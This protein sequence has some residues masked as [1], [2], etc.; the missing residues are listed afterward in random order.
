MSSPKNPQT[1]LDRDNWMRAV[2]ASGEPYAARCL[3]I[4]IALHLSVQKGRCD[5]GHKALRQDTGMSTRSVERWAARLERDGWLGIKH[6]GRGHTNSY[7]L[8]TPAAAM[9]R[10]HVAD[11]KPHMTRQR[12]ADQTSFLDF[13]PPLPAD[14][15]RHIASDDPP[16][17]VGQKSVLNN[18]KRKAEK[19]DSPADFA[20]RPE[21]DKPTRRRKNPDPTP[22]GADLADAFD[23]FWAAY[24]RKVAKEAAR[25]AF[26][27]A[28]EGVGNPDTLVAGAQRYAVERSGEPPKYT[29]HP[30]TWLNAG[31]W[32]DE[33]PGA[34]IIDQEGNVV[35]V[36][37]P[38]PQRRRTGFTAVADQLI[39]ELEAEGKLNTWQW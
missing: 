20:P 2:L 21:E 32:E 24:P 26:A 19:K 23:R 31:C 18:E 36:E 34:P 37:Q 3:A 8:T 35:A 13:D 29:K 10:Q 30:A 33:L 6:G 28:V 12:V 16:H 25:K 9:T 1:F 14:M 27:K 38:P 5:P 15:T 39:A 4:A 7:I 17:A 22:T 11:Q